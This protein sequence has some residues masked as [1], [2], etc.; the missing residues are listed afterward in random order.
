[1]WHC[2]LDGLCRRPDAD[3]GGDR[4]TRRPRQR[5]AEEDLS[6]KARVRRMDGHDAAHR[7]ASRLRCRRACARAP[8]APADGSYRI[9]GQKIFI[10]YGEHDL[11]DNII[12]FVLARLPDAPPGTRGISLFLVPKFL[13]KP[14]G[15][16]GARND[17]RAHSVE[18]KLGIH[19]S[20]TCTMI[21]GDDGGAIGYLIGAGK[22]R[23]G[24]HVHHDEPRP[25]RRRPAGRRHRRARDAAGARLCARPPARP[26]GRHQARRDGADHRPSRRA[27]HAADH[28]RAHASGARDL[29]RDRD[30][31]RSRRTQRGRS[32]AQGRGAAR[33]AAHAGRQGVLDRYR[34]RGRLARRAGARRHGLYRGDRRRAAFPRR[35]DRRDL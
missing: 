17:V 30:R 24:L 11:T 29:L 12:H 26:R 22:C 9:T 14:D 33:L 15:S 3:H 27:A 6:G 25:P 2:G 32:R 7:A 28:A 16:L 31:A 19:G 23:H 34:Q 13:L 5:R 18:H 21:F 20:P 8:S 1:M 4:R 10:T 35:A